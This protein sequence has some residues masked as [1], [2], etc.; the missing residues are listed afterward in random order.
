MAAVVFLVEVA[1]VDGSSHR[2]RQENQRV[3]E[4]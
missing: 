1:A 3:K 4:W 2:E